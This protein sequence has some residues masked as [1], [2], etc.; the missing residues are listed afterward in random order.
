MT[1][2]DVPVSN[3]PRNKLAILWHMLFEEGRN[4]GGPGETWEEFAEEAHRRYDPKLRSRGFHPRQIQRD[5]AELKK[6]EYL[7]P[8]ALS[9]RLRE[10][11]TLVTGDGS[12]ENPF[13]VV[14]DG[15]YY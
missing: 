14:I 1:D 10:L 6:L 11:L 4:P 15:G 7:P 5:V 3:P 9:G 8:D 2:A 13:K 12:P